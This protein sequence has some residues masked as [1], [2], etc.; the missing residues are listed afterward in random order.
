VE[1][2][3]MKNKVVAR[4]RRGRRRTNITLI[5]T[6]ITINRTNTTIN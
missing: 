6:I 5:R 2:R 4:E 1:E 3:K